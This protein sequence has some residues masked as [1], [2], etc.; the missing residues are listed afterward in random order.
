[1]RPES[2]QIVTT[3]YCTPKGQRIDEM[4]VTVIDNVKEVEVLFA[5]TKETRIIPKPIEQTIRS[6]SEGGAADRERA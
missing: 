1:M 3:N 6:P 5:V 4:S 2:I